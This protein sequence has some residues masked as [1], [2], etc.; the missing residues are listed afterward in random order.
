MQGG[1]RPR[2]ETSR[3]LRLGRWLANHAG[4]GA[5]ITGILAGIMGYVL[6]EKSGWIVQLTTAAVFAL[7]AASPWI[8]AARAQAEETDTYRRKE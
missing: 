1:H 6:T 3:W 7:A 2:D 5:L 8:S 4:P